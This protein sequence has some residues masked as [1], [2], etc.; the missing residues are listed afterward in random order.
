[1][2][3]LKQSRLSQTKLSNEQDKLVEI[4]SPVPIRIQD[5]IEKSQ[6]TT[7]TSEVNER[8]FEFRRQLMM[9]EFLDKL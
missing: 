7:I 6:K 4:D 9:Q 8:D 2:K 1:M 5:M 3:T